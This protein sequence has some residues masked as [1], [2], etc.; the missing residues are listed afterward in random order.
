MKHI[1]LWLIPA[2][3][4]AGSLLGWLLAFLAIPS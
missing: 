1:D 4:V 3:L 2:A